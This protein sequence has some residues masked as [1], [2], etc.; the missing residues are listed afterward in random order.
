MLQGYNSGQSSPLSGS[1]DSI[2]TPTGST[3]APPRVDSM[4]KIVCTQRDRFQTK[5]QKAELVRIVL[6]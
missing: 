3:N 5:L 4:L 6:F 2:P 1:S